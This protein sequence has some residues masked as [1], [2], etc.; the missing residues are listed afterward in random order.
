MQPSEHEAPVQAT[1]S[2]APVH[3]A[4]EPFVP[5]RLT[6]VEPKLQP[7]GTVKVEAQIE[8]PFLGTFSPG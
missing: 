8:P 6:W 3:Q 4:K 2:P 7:R 5:P 1:T